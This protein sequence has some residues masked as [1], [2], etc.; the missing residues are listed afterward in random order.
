MAGHHCYLWWRWWSDTL[1]LT[2]IRWCLYSLSCFIQVVVEISLQFHQFI[3]WS[4]SSIQTLEF[5]LFESLRTTWVLLLLL[6]SYSVWT[7]ESLHVN[8]LN[9][10]T[11]AQINLLW[12]FHKNLIKPRFICE[13]SSTSL[14]DVSKWLNSFYKAVFPM[15]NNLWVEKLRKANFPC[16]SSWILNDSTGVV[17][18]IK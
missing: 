7:C 1:W 5:L 3:I 16:V 18:V 15:V 10:S 14:A 11:S 17:D 12:K 8:N 6:T 13:P 2:L 4:T 9:P